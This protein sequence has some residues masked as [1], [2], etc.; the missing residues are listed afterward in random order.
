MIKDAPEEMRCPWSQQRF[1]RPVGRRDVR[2]VLVLGT[3]EHRGSHREHGQVDEAR[4]RH[5]QTDVQATG[6]KQPAQRCRRVLLGVSPAQSRMQVDDVGHDGRAED[7]GGEVDGMGVGKARHRHSRDNGHRLGMAEQELGD[8]AH[9]DS[10]EH[11]ADDEFERLKAAALEGEQQPAE[12]RG[13]QGS[14]QEGHPEQELEPQGGADELGQVGRDRQDFGLEP[15][16]VGTPGRQVIADQRRQAGA[17][18]EAE[19]RREQLN[20]H[21]HQVRPEDDPEQRIAVFGARL[22]VGGVV[23][24]ID[25]ADRGD[26]GRAEQRQAWAPSAP[27]GRNRGTSVLHSAPVGSY[28]PR[29][30]RICQT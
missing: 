20:Q 24:G 10:A 14:F 27:D 23:P 16:Q 5:G 11:A 18:G 2:D 6:T 22:D 28:G 15:V 9:R 19:L 21:G 3:V 7:A 29:S 12:R 17:R 26:E 30:L 13:A 1:E 4:E 8:V 25:V